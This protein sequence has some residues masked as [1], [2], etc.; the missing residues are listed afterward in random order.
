MHFHLLASVTVVAKDVDMW[1]Y[2]VGQLVGE[3]FHMR[4]STTGYGAILVVEF[5]HSSST[6]AAGGLVSGHVHAA[7]FPAAMQSVEGHNHLDC[8]AVGIGNNAARCAEGII[9]VDFRHNQ[10]HVV[11]HAESAGIVDHNSAVTSDYISKLER[12]ATT[13]RNQ[14]EV[15]TREVAFGREEFDSDGFTTK[16]NSTAGAAFRAEQ[17]QIVDGEGTPL[18]QFKK[19]TADS[20]AGP[21][22]CNVHL[23]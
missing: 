5:L 19:F 17:S 16:R 9:A 3:A 15:Y 4:S 14:G 21:D 6:G 7:D 12:S 11:V 22:N 13:C 18:E 23:A 1:D 8:G 20:S 2:V 10:R